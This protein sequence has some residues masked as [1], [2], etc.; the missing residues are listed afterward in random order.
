MRSR[1]ESS[2]VLPTKF[3]TESS[4]ASGVGES[5]LLLCL[6]SNCILNCMQ[7]E[8]CDIKYIHTV[9]VYE[10]DMLNTDLKIRM[11]FTSPRCFIEFL[12]SRSAVFE[13]SINHGIEDVH[14]RICSYNECIHSSLFVAEKEKGR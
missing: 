12:L 10:G 4:T 5:R 7:T 13:S 1:V 9:R 8:L 2:G 14:V 11:S 6:E 3:T